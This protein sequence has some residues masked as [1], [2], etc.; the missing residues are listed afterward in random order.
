M[1]QWY[2]VWRRHGDLSSVLMRVGVLFLLADAF[3]RGR[4]ST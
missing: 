1:A 3:T 4:E 2:D